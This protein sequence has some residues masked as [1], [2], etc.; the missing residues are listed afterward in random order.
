MLMAGDTW[1]PYSSSLARPDKCCRNYRY[2]IRELNLP[3][4]WIP[5]AIIA[6]FGAFL[7]AIATD[8]AGSAASATAVMVVPVIIAAAAPAAAVV[9]IAALWLM[10]AAGGLLPAVAA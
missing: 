7:E 4:E 5:V 1:R 10:S 6:F 9:V 8:L 2:F 3:I